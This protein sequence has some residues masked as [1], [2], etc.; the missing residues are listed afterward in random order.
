M[1]SSGILN[2]TQRKQSLSSSNNN[3]PSAAPHQQI[4]IAKR[5]GGNVTLNVNNHNTAPQATN[6]INAVNT[7]AA[8][9]VSNKTRL[10][11]NELFD[12][13]K[14][15]SKQ[16]PPPLAPKVANL[17]KHHQK[18]SMQHQAPNNDQHNVKQHD[19]HNQHSIPNQHITQ[20][21]FQ[22]LQHRSKTQDLIPNS[23]RLNQK[24]VYKLL[25]DQA[26][27]NLQYNNQAQQ[28]I[29][30]NPP[31]QA[32]IHNLNN[33]HTIHPHKLN[34][35]QATHPQKANNQLTTHPQ[36]PNSQ[37]TTHPQ[38]PNSQPTTHPQ[39]TNNNQY[40]NNH[41]PLKNTQPPQAPFAP[42]L[43]PHH[44]LNGQPNTFNAVVGGPQGCNGRGQWFINNIILF[45]LPIIISLTDII[46]D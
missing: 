22:S 3:N 5:N 37:P 30:G 4:T 15:G 36:K 27:L 34:N 28:F 38:K 41:Q 31:I 1:K 11:I 16:Q 42:P 39:K 43:P 35:N 20:Q 6:N 23:H 33:Q 46:S 2:L 40:H 26:Q 10:S 8:N 19:P 24:V 44:W 17:F 29:Q 18:S 9:I 14:R 12:Y 13:S 21:F 45:F 7:N 32:S 25:M